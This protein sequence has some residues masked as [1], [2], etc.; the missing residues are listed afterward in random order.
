[1]VRC[2]VHTNS[3]S[4]PCPARGGG[5]FPR[6]ISVRIDF[7]SRVQ[8]SSSRSHGH[9][10]TVTYTM[11]DELNAMSDEVLAL[12]VD[13]ALARPLT[14]DGVGLRRREQVETR[15]MVHNVDRVEV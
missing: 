7:G 15:Q 6:H 13:T 8:A 4:P 9:D 2:T 14:A 12:H 11:V 1:M 3:A 5:R 10:G